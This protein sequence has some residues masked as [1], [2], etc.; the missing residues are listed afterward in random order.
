MVQRKNRVDIHPSEIEDEVNQDIR[1]AGGLTPRFH[2]SWLRRW[3]LLRLVLCSVLMQSTDCVRM[4]QYERPCMGTADQDVKTSEVY[5][6]EN[7]PFRFDHPSL[8][9]YGNCVF[10]APKGACES[11]RGSILFRTTNS[12]YGSKPPCVHTMPLS[13]H[14]RNHKYWEHLARV[15]MYR[16]RGFNTALDR[17]RV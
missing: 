8:W 4:M 5:K 15:G 10:T 17:S 12:E 1:A 16:N 11:G 7:L 2:H 6:T 13:Y 3:V 9:S 14:P